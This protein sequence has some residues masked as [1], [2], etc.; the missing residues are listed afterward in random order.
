MV[1]TAVP[2]DR[3]NSI[4][5]KIKTTTTEF[6]KG[7]VSSSYNIQYQSTG[8]GSLS[9]LD[10]IEIVRIICGSFEAV[11]ALSDDGVEN[12]FV[13]VVFFSTIHRYSRRKRRKNSTTTMVVAAAVATEEEEDCCLLFSLFC[14]VCCYHH[15]RS[16]RL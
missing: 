2:F 16:Q 4:M 8:V 12:N 10:K 15:H 7:M 1:L 11:M 3:I 5:K 6:F 14:L 9:K 13:A